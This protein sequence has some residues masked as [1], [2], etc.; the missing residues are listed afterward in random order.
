[1]RSTS[2]KSANAMAERSF[3]D[4]ALFFFKEFWFIIRV[5]RELK[6]ALRPF[7][8]VFFRAGKRIMCDFAKVRRQEKCDTGLHGASSELN[9]KSP[10][11]ITKAGA[12]GACELVVLLLAS[13]ASCGNVHSHR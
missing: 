1:M 4:L 2:E 3:F 10:P 13:S 8:F 12:G 9:S 11:L 5:K 6:R 7:F